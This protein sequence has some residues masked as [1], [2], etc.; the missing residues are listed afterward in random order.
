MRYF[1]KEYDPENEEMWAETGLLH[2]VDFELFP[3]EHC[4]KGE[5]FLRYEGVDERTIRINRCGCVNA[6]EQECSGHRNF[7]R[8][9]KIQG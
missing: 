4:V 2:D 5:E 8:E 1:A 7:F 3:D 6:T 9:E